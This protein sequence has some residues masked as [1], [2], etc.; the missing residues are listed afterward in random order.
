MLFGTQAL[1]NAALLNLVG[2]TN[3]A[4][5]VLLESLVRLLKFVVVSFHLI[6][7]FVDFLDNH[8]F[9]DSLEL[10]RAH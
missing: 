2:R 5:I 3:Q 8:V 1:L 4:T 10:L 7:D 9:G 6:E